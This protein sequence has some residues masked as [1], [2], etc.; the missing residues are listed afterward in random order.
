MNDSIVEIKKIT[1]KFSKVIANKNV[2]FNIRKNSVHALLGEN[3]AGKSTLVKILYGLLKPD[4]GTI[5]YNNDLLNIASPS[6]AKKK[7]IGMVFQHFSLFE[8]LTVR[9][10]LILG[11]DEKISYSDLSKKLN[12]IS[13][14]YEL[15]LDLDAPIVTLSAGEKQRVE[16]V[17]ILLQDPQLLIMDEPTSVLTPQE[18]INLFKT[19]NALIKEGRTILYITHKLEEV[20]NLCDEVTIMRNGEVIDTCLIE[21][22]T[23]ESLATKMLGEK[24]GEIKTDYSH[25]SNNI[26]FEVLNL[27]TTYNDPFFTDLKNIQFDVKEGEI[28]GIAGVAGN[29]QSELMDILTGENTIID[30]GSII[31]NKINIERFNP[32]KRRDLSIA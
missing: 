6:D 21:N 2:S 4:N 13:S 15:P 3:G 1:K 31:F 8:S 22:Q 28:Y 18:V 5:F 32:K 20:I 24:L 16:I 9:E 7:G 19:L 11:I 23:A 12:D 14:R 27:S 30:S 25:V 26:N 10:N 17:R 29:G